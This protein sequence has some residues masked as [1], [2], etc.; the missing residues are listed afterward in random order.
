MSSTKAMN[1][2]QMLV[3]EMESLKNAVDVREGAEQVLNFVNNNAAQDPLIAGDNVW[4][5]TSIKRGPCGC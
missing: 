2:K 3:N 5:Q 1:E 4:V